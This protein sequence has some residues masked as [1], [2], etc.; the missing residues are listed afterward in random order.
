MSNAIFSSRKISKLYVMSNVIFSSKKIS[1]LC[2][3]NIVFINIILYIYIINIISIYS[4]CICL[5]FSLIFLSKL[6]RS[7]INFKQ[8]NSLSKIKTA[9]NIYPTIKKRE[10]STISVSLYPK[11]K[12][13]S[14]ELEY[15]LEKEEINK[16]GSFDKDLSVAKTA[17]NLKD[18]EAAKERLN[19]IY[20]RM[21]EVPEVEPQSKKV[22]TSGFED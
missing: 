2:V 5:I 12:N 14:F 8:V 17:Q 7:F 19:K 4:F 16:E 11:R 22:R 13:S 1:I 20:D 6:K 3:V 15:Q 18:I 10:F 21:D 9:N